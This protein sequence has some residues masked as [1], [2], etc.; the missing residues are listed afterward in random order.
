M[1]GRAL[2]TGRSQRTRCTSSGRGSAAGTED[3]SAN[4]GQDIYNRAIVTAE[5]PDGQGIV[6]PRLTQATSGEMTPGA[7]QLSNPG[8]EVNTTGWAASIGTLTR[9]TGNGDNSVAAFAVTALNDVAASSSSY[10]QPLVVGRRYR[11]R[12]RCKYSGNGSVSP[13]FAQISVSPITSTTGQRTVTAIKVMS[14][15]LT[16]SY[17]TFETADFIAE[18]TSPSVTFAALMSTA[19]GSLFFDNVEFVEA[20]DDAR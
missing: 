16:T 12:A 19:S 3:A 18:T 8:A 4:S 9:N 6:R 14:S 7:G 15:L 17:Q 10:A 13:P 2:S 20:T 5:T 11:V 1:S